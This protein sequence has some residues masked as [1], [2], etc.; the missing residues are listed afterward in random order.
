MGQNPPDVSKAASFKSSRS[1]IRKK[2][3]HPQEKEGGA[4]GDDK[5]G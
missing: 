5:N 2:K 3:P 1:T 4:I